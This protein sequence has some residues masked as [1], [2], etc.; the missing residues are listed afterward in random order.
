MDWP[1]QYLEVSLWA[2][3]P[4]VQRNNN[5]IT[6]NADMLWW[7]NANKAG[8]GSPV[9]EKEVLNTDYLVLPFYNSVL[10]RSFAFWIEKYEVKNARTGVFKKCF[11]QNIIYRSSKLLHKQQ[12]PLVKLKLGTSVRASSRY[13][14]FWLF[15][16]KNVVCNVSQNY[17]ATV[18]PMRER[19]EV[20]QTELPLFRGHCDAAV[21]SA[22]FNWREGYHFKTLK[23]FFSQ[24]NTSF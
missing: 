19:G 21:P 14:V 3:V 18:S 6:Y 11:P 23:V 10:P 5:N 7:S 1:C 4:S 13:H 16:R 15:E 9:L 12:I 2:S 22:T 8:K 24:Q 20:V 17:L